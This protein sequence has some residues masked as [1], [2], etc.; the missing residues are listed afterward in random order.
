MKTSAKSDKYIKKAI[1]CLL[2]K[3]NESKIKYEN[4][5]ST[6]THLFFLKKEK[7]HKR[8]NVIANKF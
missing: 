6:S 3:V 5:S 7:N 8:K 1:V 4:I 2:K